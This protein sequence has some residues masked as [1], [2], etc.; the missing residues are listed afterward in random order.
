M[1][2][3]TGM[4]LGSVSHAVILDAGCTVALVARVR[5]EGAPGTLTDM[6]R[7]GLPEGIRACL[8]DLDGVLTDT[9]AVHRAA[10]GEVFDEV[11]ATHGEPPFTDQDYLRYVDGKRRSDGVRDFLASRGIAPP[12]GS[13]D[14]PPRAETIAGVGNRKNV[15]LLARLDRDG[16]QVLRGAADY[17]GAVREAGVRTA[18]VTSSANGAQV[19]RAAGLEHLVDERVDGL[20]A[21]REGLPG[22]PAPDTFLAAARLLGV[23]PDAA[24]VFEDALAGV[25]SGQT[26][27]FGFVVGGGGG[28]QAD[29]LRAA[30]ADVVVNELS[31]LLGPS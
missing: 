6:S 26:G 14:D 29:A 1:H 9:A 17:L 13:P 22:K 24:A 31:D 2:K 5:P 28:Q 23:E 10:W 18:V 8:F 7:F 25:A 19:I 11:L 12:E 20:V 27:R 4:P 16:V 3:T 30:G 15:L 21:E